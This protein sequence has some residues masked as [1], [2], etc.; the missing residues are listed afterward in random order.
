M[1]GS[2][3]RI[4]RIERIALKPTPGACDVPAATD[5]EPTP[6]HAL[7]PHVLFART[8]CHGAVKII[9]SKRYLKGKEIGSWK[10]W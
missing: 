8:S 3:F 6:E 2:D 10:Q 7:R 4:F 5:S 9:L 1:F